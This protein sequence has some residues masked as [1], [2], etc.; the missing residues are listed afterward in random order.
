MG[1]CEQGLQVCLWWMVLAA[2]PPS[3]VPPTYKSLFREAA[4]AGI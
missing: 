4:F 2:F 3:E 1:V